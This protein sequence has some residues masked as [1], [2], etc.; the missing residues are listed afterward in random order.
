MDAAAIAKRIGDPRLAID[1]G[2]KL[3]TA[4]MPKRLAMGDAEIAMLNEALS[5]YRAEGI[6]PGYQGVFEKRYT[7]DFVA[8]MGGGYAD[9]VATGTASI[10][11]AVAALDLPKGS[12]V[13]VSPITDPGSLAAITMNGLKPRLAD[14]KPGSYNM[15]AAQ[16]AARITPQVS[17]VM[18]VH[19]SGQAAEIDKIVEAAHAKGLK[20]IEDCSQSHGARVN[21]RPIGTFGDVAAFST[22]YR[23]I[24][25]TG[26]SGG[27]VYSRDL[28]I[29]RNAL[30]HAD[31]G[32]PRWDANFDDRNPETY[33]FPAL[34]WNTDELS[35][36]I[37]IASLRRLTDTVVRRLAFVSELASLLA[38]ADDLMFRLHDW[39][40]QDSPFILP[41]YVDLARATRPKIEV[42]RAV[43]AEGIDLNPHYRY[44]V[45]DWPFIKP[46][47]ADGF[48]TPVARDNRDRSFCLY[49][50][51]NYG[52]T[53]A[54]DIAAALLK[55]HRALASDKPRS[56]L[57]SIPIVAR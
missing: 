4:P 48:D 22:M 55:V 40:P 13:I 38:E 6:D 41:V 9:A 10:W 33:L 30:A 53:E 17:A 16:M 44:L 1:G 11:L 29:F 51:E 12:E 47:L 8:M 27:L 18:A 21:G 45:A 34:N 43:L 14:A 23:K 54:A 20:V 36:A 52:S 5:A 46:Y 19:S 28:K 50:N 7:D 26:G 31:R 25:M 3:R 49:L 56:P 35:C 2:P 24:H 15:G 37:G 42:A 39:T 57:S 32:K